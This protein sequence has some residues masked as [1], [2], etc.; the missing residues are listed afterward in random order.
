MWFSL[1][2]FYY[3]RFLNRS[4]KDYEI[5][6]K[7]NRSELDKL[8][9]NRL[10]SLLNYAY[11][12][13]PFY[14]KLWDSYGISYEIESLDDLN[15]FPI[16]DK[17]MLQKAIFNNQISTAYFSKKHIKQSTTGSS[18]SPF[19]FPSDFESE[20]EKFVVRYRLWKWYNVTPFTL[21]VKFWRS[22]FKKSI[23]E[24][25]REFLNFEFNFSIYDP[26]Y[27]NETKIDENRLKYFISK[28]NFIKPNVIE[29]FPS[30]LV[31]LSKYIQ[32]N[33]I[34]LN[35]SPKAIVTGA[36]MLNIVDRLLIQSTFNSIVYNR[37][38]GTESS[39]IAHECSAQTLNDH[40]LHIQEDRIILESNE[41]N[42]FIF[43]DLSTRSMPFIRYKN[44]DCGVISKDLL[45]ECGCEFNLITSIDGRV[46]EFFVLPD[47]SKISS[48]IWQNY[49][50]SNSCVSNYKMIQHKL[51]YVQVLWVRNELKF[52]NIDFS[53]LQLKIRNALDG[54]NVVWEEVEDISRGPGGKLNQHIN[55]I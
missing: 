43:T 48:H 27:P 30:F 33:K 31:L 49:F 26:L 36:E 11:F 40:Y 55:L 2:Y 23:M 45:C 51:D 29:G 34:Q 44:G 10:K 47:G 52:D 1:K 46:N 9:F 24:Y 18:G 14:R 37:Y 19:V 6:P 5:N 3:S 42:E 12:N 21:R 38:G 35:F 7:L 15:K 50:K 16:V 8:R 39:I 13:V 17:Y 41:N 25:F 54:I 28:L 4:L 53:E 32:D 20:L 22:S